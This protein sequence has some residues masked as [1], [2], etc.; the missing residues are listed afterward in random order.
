MNIS[1]GFISVLYKSNRFIFHQFY[2]PRTVSFETRLFTCLMPDWGHNFLEFIN[3]GFWKKQ[4]KKASSL[5]QCFFMGL[6]TVYLVDRKQAKTSRLS[7]TEKPVA[8]FILEKSRFFFFKKIKK[9][10]NLRKLYRNLTKKCE[11][12]RKQELY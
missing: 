7:E 2:S 10:L 3:E 11:N 5:A 6:F 1:F 4:K 12:I 8:W 9:T